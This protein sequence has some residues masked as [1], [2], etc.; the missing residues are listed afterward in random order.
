MAQSPREND[1]PGQVAAPRAV[2]WALGRQAGQRRTGCFGALAM[3]LHAACWFVADFTYHRTYGHF[4]V[5]DDP[6]LLRLSTAT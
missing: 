1:R 2:S 4:G 6:R 3:V 5:E